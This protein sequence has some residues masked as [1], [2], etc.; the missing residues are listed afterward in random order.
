[1]VR[2]FNEKVVVKGDFAVRYGQS[3]AIFVNNKEPGIYIAWG[4]GKKGFFAVGDGKQNEI[5]TI[6]PKSANLEIGSKNNEG[7][8]QIFDKNEMP[9]FEFRSS[10][11]RLFIGE[12]KVPGNLVVM[13]GKYRVFDFYGKQALLEIGN[14]GNSGEIKLLDEKGQVRVHCDGKSGDI[15]LR[16]GDCAENF[17]V[18]ESKNVTAGTV[19]VIGENETMQPC[20]NPYDKR[21]A[22]I[23]SG[24]QGLSP[25]II[26][27]SQPDN[28]R[29]AIPIALSGKTYCKVDASYASIETGDLLTTSS[30]NG[31]AMKAEDPTRSFGSVI[32]KAL[33]PIKKGKATIP[34]LVA[35]Q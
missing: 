15:K 8:L 30:T 34:V 7:S 31:Y 6:G 16:G 2:N 33:R 1:M 28:K 29:N 20:K 9:V 18:I 35:L 10:E 5:L 14:Q 11:S 23:A 22:G 19:L 24:A 3:D 4:G 21:V 32:G 25:G 17:P 27:G 26:L 13:D 12:E